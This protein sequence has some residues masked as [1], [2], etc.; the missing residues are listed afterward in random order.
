MPPQSDPNQ[1]QPPISHPPQSGQYPQ[2]PPNAQQNWSQPNP[3]P[4]QQQPTNKKLYIVIGLI[5]LA[6]V[7]VIA[8]FI[9][10]SSGPDDTD[11]DTAS[12]SGSDTFSEID[13]DASDTARRDSLKDRYEELT[14]DFQALATEIGAAECPTPEEGQ[15]EPSS[16]QTSAMRD[17]L[18][19]RLLTLRR[20]KDE[21]IS[22]SDLTLKE[23]DSEL[24]ALSAKMLEAERA[25]SDALDEIFRRC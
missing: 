5:I 14:E 6:V 2:Q 1:Q 9:L 21:S 23:G 17:D 16:Q 15:T 10:I 19:E 3:Q 22:I 25:V 4:P 8:A 12:V 20:K 11:D 13:E 24:R 7:I 18:R